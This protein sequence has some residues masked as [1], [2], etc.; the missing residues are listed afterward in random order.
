MERRQQCRRALA[1]RTPEQRQ[2]SKPVSIRAPFLFRREDAFDRQSY[3][4]IDIT[5]LGWRR[6]LVQPLERDRD[7]PFD[8]EQRQ[9]IRIHLAHFPA[10]HRLGEDIR[11]RP[12][13]LLVLGST[14][15]LLPSLLVRAAGRDAQREIEAEELGVLAEERQLRAKDLAQ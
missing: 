15:P 7:R 9:A 10:L 1:P 12:N 4:E 5:L 3:D 11:K 6:A 8:Q 14:V 13:A 2:S